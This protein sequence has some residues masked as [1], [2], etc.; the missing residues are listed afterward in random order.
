MITITQVNA[1][2]DQLDRSTRNPRDPDHA[3]RCLYRHETAEGVCRCL[4]GELIYRLCG[5]EVANQLSESQSVDSA[6]NRVLLSPLFEE[7]AYG[8]LYCLQGLADMRNMTWGDAIV[9]ARL[10]FRLQAA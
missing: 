10:D 1:E 9:R 4:A 7:R 8:F 6:D 3:G 2:L 5:E